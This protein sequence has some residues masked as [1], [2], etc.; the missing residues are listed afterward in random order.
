MKLYISGGRHCYPKTEDRVQDVIAEFDDLDVVFLESRQAPTSKLTRLI[1]WVLAPLLFSAI[2]G[3]KIVKG[4]C[5][6]LLGSDKEIADELAD[7]YGTPLIRVDKSVHVIVTE[8]R[9][10]WAVSNWGLLAIPGILTYEQPGLLLISIPLAAY[11]SM[12]LM[13]T[14][15]AGSMNERNIEILHL[16]DSISAEEGYE[17]GCIITG[18]DHE[19]G[20]S[21]F[22]SIFD[23]VRIA[24]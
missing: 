20:L 19:S 24:E 12:I 22:A 23:R 7:H 10:L 16:I 1:N 6:A 11:F 2:V 18:A 14:F 13:A 5:A 9:Y 4:S 3:W 17:R 8:Q 21:K 15:V